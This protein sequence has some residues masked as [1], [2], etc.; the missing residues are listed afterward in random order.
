MPNSQYLQLAKE[1]TGS[2]SIQEII[3]AANEIEKYFYQSTDISVF[4]NFLKHVKIQHPVQ[5]PV[6]YTSTGATEDFIKAVSHDRCIINK[7]R[8]IGMTTIAV[9]Y[10]LWY[11]M[12]NPSKS[13]LIVANR[14][15]Q[16]LEIMDRMR[17]F[18]EHLPANIRF[19][20]CESNKGAIKFENGSRII[21]RAM[22]P[23]SGRGMSIDILYIDELA[24]VSYAHEDAFWTSIM[25]C[26]ASTNGKV[27]IN[28]TPRHKKGLFYRLWTGE[29]EFY[30]IKIPYYRH[31]SVDEEYEKSYI[32]MLGLEKFNAEFKCEFYEETTE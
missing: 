18:Y 15:A 26:I 11:A 22:T 9:I 30:K 27:I 17:Y 21:A 6:S 31:R 10:L 12:T 14:Y 3:Q 4:E 24:Y 5:G 25:P 29:N 8:Q 7:S 32:D 16:S 20:I 23:D 1:L 28:S 19:S 13:I 2:T